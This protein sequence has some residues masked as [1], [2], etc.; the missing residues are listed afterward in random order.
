MPP[1]AQP[2]DY[3]AFGPTKPP[4]NSHQIGQSNK[5]S[6][7]F[8]SAPERAVLSPFQIEVFNHSDPYGIGALD[9]EEADEP[10]VVRRTGLRLEIEDIIDLSSANLLARYDGNPREHAAPAQVKKKA[11]EE[12]NWDVDMMMC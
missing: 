11:A 6:R 12:A 3:N 10:Q 5:R 1:H 7:A 4:K 8:H 9:D 2:K